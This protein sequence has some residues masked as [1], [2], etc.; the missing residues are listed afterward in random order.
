MQL[1][2]GP[3]CCCFDGR[4]THHGANGSGAGA[5]GNGG[6]GCGGCGGHGHGGG[7]GHGVCG[8]GGGGGG[9]CGGQGGDMVT[10]D[11]A[12]SRLVVVTHQGGVVGAGGD[13]E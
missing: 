5:G 2:S 1:I 11:V 7:G 10:C 9:S 13:L 3:C 8:G 6:H 12:V 4:W